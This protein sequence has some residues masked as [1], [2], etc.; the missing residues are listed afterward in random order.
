MQRLKAGFTI[1]ELIIVITVI[2][3]LAAIVITSYNGAQ[4]RSRDAR[5]VANLQ[6]IGEAITSYRL[7]YGDAVT[8]SCAGGNGNTGTGWFNNSTSSGYTASILSC[9]ISKG[10]LN[11]GFVD[12]TGCADTSG[13]AAAGYT[14]TRTGYA[15]AKDT[16]TDPSNSNQTITVLMAKL[17][18]SGSTANLQGAN[19]LCSSSTYATNYGLNYMIRVD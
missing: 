16:C 5:R 15:Y 3:I 9:L 19:A 8:T 7:K 12:P 13:T 11:T 18:A 10:Y 17:E 6:S 2:A 1:V 4:M 14:C